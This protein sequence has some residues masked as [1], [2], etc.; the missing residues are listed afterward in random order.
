M[1]HALRPE[2][3]RAAKGTR[4]GVSVGFNDSSTHVVAAFWAYGM[5]W[6]G[7]TALWAVTGLLRLRLVV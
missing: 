6:N 1:I 2:P 7:V 3:G 5:G 4:L